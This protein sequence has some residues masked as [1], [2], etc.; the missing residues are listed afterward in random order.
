MSRTADT[1]DHPA[2]VDAHDRQGPDRTVVHPAWAREMPWWA[3]SAVLHIVLIL[4]V[5]WI[6]IAEKEKREETR[7]EAMVVSKE[8]PP[9]PYDP[10][11]KRD[12]EHVPRI[13]NPE[14]IKDPVIK[15][16]ID[17]VPTDIPK[18]TDLNKL[19]NVNQN[20][21]SVN[22][23]IGV[24][25]GA[26]G[27]LGDRRGKGSLSREGGRADTESAV[28]AALEWLYR[29][30]DADGGWKA[31]KFN[32]APGRRGP[33]ANRDPKK[34]PGDTGFEEY[35][36][37]VTALAIL[38]FTGFGHTHRDGEYDHFVKCLRKAVAY[39][40][41]HQVKSGDPRA[42]GLY[43]DPRVITDEKFG[44]EHEQWIYN[45]AIATM[46][47]S[48]LLLMS[49]DY[50]KL[51][52]SV[53][54]ATKLC[55]RARNPG[56]GW[57]YGINTSHNDTSVTGWMVLAL[58]TAKQCRIG[59]GPQD[60]KNA[61]GGALD[62]FDYASASNGKTGYLAPGDQGSRL[63]DGHGDGP[64]PYSKELSCMTG[65]GVLCRL[66]AGQKRSNPSIR[67]GVDLLSAHPPM[68]REQKGRSLSTIN[69]YYWYYATYAMFQN[70]G[71][72]WKH[73]NEKMIKA[74]VNTQR[75]EYKNDHPEVD[76]SWDPI[77]EWGIAGGRVYSTALG[78]MT[79]EVYYRYR[80]Q[81]SRARSPAS[82][83]DGELPGTQASR[84]P[85]GARAPDGLL[86][87]S[88]DVLRWDGTPE[89]DER[90]PWRGGLLRNAA[91]HASLRQL[92]SMATRPTATRPT[93]TRPTA[94]RPTARPGR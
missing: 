27:V 9:P 38:A 61:F 28:L 50:L 43:G 63:A 14:V 5:G 42:K 79:L 24:G 12:L 23:A 13:L 84:V 2:P 25:A 72:P 15:T 30:Q 7:H 73:W 41:K 54:D 19:S 59:I 20:S 81:E 49:T 8:K 70:G 35:D 18:G 16:K 55:L 71:K 22:D 90:P 45:H 56:R 65:V 60:Y 52:K 82:D 6:V 40:L 77:G 31:A 69:V 29:H 91:G 44:E 66:F 17:E 64:Y 83:P 93:A 26:A 89:S 67:A 58:K 57:R 33:S 1:P 87:I 80:R 78:A 37:G 62:W 94:T 51:K 21:E 32:D 86:T 4:G 53:L 74:L 92:R 75:A 36:I 88:Q 68:W 76:G 46:A 48:E 11:K 10:K 47:M 3:T 39:M 85:G 34:Y